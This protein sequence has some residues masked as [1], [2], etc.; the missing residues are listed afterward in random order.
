MWL[1]ICLLLACSHTAVNF[2]GASASYVSDQLPYF[3]FL[4]SYVI[5]LLEGEC[6]ALFITVQC[7]L[8]VL[9]IWR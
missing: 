7:L 8:A 4:S 1:T 2:V 6:Y 5:V 3:C 9:A